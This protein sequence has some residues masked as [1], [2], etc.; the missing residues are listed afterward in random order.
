M[1][2]QEFDSIVQRKRLEAAQ[3]SKEK[4]DS[5]TTIYNL[6]DFDADSA[7]YGEDV[8]LRFGGQEGVYFDA[9]ETA[10]YDEQGQ[11]K[12]YP[13]LDKSGSKKWELHKA[14]YAKRFGIPAEEVTQQMLHDEADKQAL[15][16]Q[17]AIA[18][19][20]GEY[21]PELGVVERIPGQDYNPTGL[22]YAA[23]VEMEPQL[24]FPEA[25][26]ELHGTGKYG[27]P[28]GDYI[29][30]VTGANIT[31]QLNTPEQ[32]AAY[33]FYGNRLAENRKRE[34][35]KLLGVDDRSGFWNNFTRG[36]S[37]NVDSLQA[38]GYGL[39]ALIAD[40]TGDTELAD[41]MLAD[42]Q[43]N[44]AEALE[45][46]KH[47]PD[48]QDVNWT[49]PDD[50]LSALGY[51]VGQAIPS[52]L[53][54]FT[55]GGIG[56]YAAKKAV[57]RKIKDWSKDKTKEQIAKRVVKS[58]RIGQVLGAATVGTGMSTGE[59]YGDL[60]TE[61]YRSTEAQL[62]ALAGGTVAGALDVITPARLLKKFGLGD[63]A[64]QKIKDTLVKE[65]IAK[66]FANVG[67][68]GLKVGVTEGVTE[69]LQFV[70]EEITK[71]LVKTGEL[72]EFQSEQFQ[73][74]VINNIGWG[75][76]GGKSIGGT[77]AI[78]TE[79]SK[80]IGGNKKVTQ[81][82]YKEVLQEAVKEEGNIPDADKQQAEARLNETMTAIDAV[83]IDTNIDPNVPIM[84]KV[85][86]Y[87]QKLAELG[88]QALESEDGRLQ[89]NTAQ[90][91]QALKEAVDEYN[92]VNKAPVNEKVDAA[93]TQAVERIEKINEKLEDPEVSKKH[94]KRLE[95]ERKNQATLVVALDRTDGVEVKPETIQQFKSAT[96]D[97]EY[98]GKE[99]KAT[100]D[101]IIDVAD[102][103]EE[104]T[105]TLQEVET[106]EEAAP[107]EVAEARVTWLQN[108][109]ELIALRKQQEETL[110][111]AKGEQQRADA[112]E[113]IDYINQRLAKGDKDFDVKPVEVA[114]TTTT[115]N[116]YSLDTTDLTNQEIITEAEKVELTEEDAIT[117]DSRKEVV[118]ITQEIDQLLQN[119][120]PLQ[121][122]H[123]DV[124]R[125]T[126]E[127][128]RGFNAYLDDAK[129]N[130]F[131]ATKFDQFKD[132]LHTK[133]EQFTKAIGEATK[134]NKKVYISKD[135][136]SIHTDLPAD[137]IEVSYTGKK[138][139]NVGY[140]NYWWVT[141]KSQKLA[142]LID[143]EAQLANKTEK[144]INQIIKNKDVRQEQAD[145]Q[146][147]IQQANEQ[148]EKLVQKQKADFGRLEDV[149][150]TEPTPSPEK[151]EKRETEKPKPE[152][153]TKPTVTPTEKANTFLGRL[154][155]EYVKLARTDFKV[156][157]LF[158]TKQADRKSFFSENKN[159][160]L[161]KE[162]I[163]AELKALGV[164]DNDFINTVAN[165]FV[166]FKKAFN[167]HVK[168]GLNKHQQDNGVLVLSDSQFVFA[169]KDGNL[170]DEVLFSMMLSVVEWSMINRVASNSTNSSALAQFLFGDSKQTAY[171][172]D[173]QYA[174]FGDMGLPIRNVAKNLSNEIL[175]NLNIKSIKSNSQF[176]EGILEKHYDGKLDPKNTL[177]KDPIIGKRVGTALGLLAIETA[178]HMHLP[179]ADTKSPIIEGGLIDL[180]HGKYDVELFDDAEGRFENI[181]KGE[182]L[183]NTIKVN[184]N[185]ATEKFLEKFKN[186][187][188][189]LKL[190]KGVDTTFKGIHAQPV[191]EVQ[192]TADDSLFPLHTKTKRL[193]KTMQNVAWTG[194]S[195]ELKLFNLVDDEN[196]NQLIELK[197]IEEQHETVR[198][199]VEVAN[200]EKL[201]DVQQVR[202]FMLSGIKSFYY[203]YKVMSQHR[204]RIDSNDINGQRSKIHRALF[205]PEKLTAKVESASDR[206]VFKVAVAQALGF[207]IDKTDLPEVLDYFN[208][209]HGNLAVTNI[210]HTLSK[211][212]VDKKLFNKQLK[213]L[214]ETDLVSPSMHLLEGLV[215]LSQYRE[216]RAFTTRIGIETDGITNG[217]A[218]GL[219]QF[220]G[221]KPEELKARLAK[222]GVF[223]NEGEATQTY[224]KF[225]KSGAT[226]VY[227]S[228][229]ELI[230]KAF[231][232]LDPNINQA[233]GVLHG[234]LIDT[235]TGKIEKFARNL[236]KTPLM[237]SN[238]GAGL[239]KVIDDIV[240]SIVPG[241]YDKMADIQTRYDKAT[242]EQEKQDLETEL[243]AIED[244]V[245]E[246][247]RTKVRLVGWMTSEKTSLYKFKFKYNTTRKLN[248]AFDTIYRK[249]VSDALNELIGPI[250]KARE[251]IVQ[252]VELQYFAF[253]YKFTEATKGVRDITLK[254]AIARDLANKYMP[255]TSGPWS[256]NSAELIQLVKVVASTDARVQI[257]TKPIK[258][259]L[260]KDGKLL[261]YRSPKYVETQ[262]SAVDYRSP[263]VSAAIGMIQNID[264]VLLGEV[265]LHNPNVIPIYDAEISSVTDAFKNTTGYN[266][267]FKRVSLQYSVLEDTLQQTRDVL[268]NLTDAEIKEVMLLVKK[269]GYI[270]EQLIKARRKAKAEPD[271]EK[272]YKILQN[273]YINDLR[274]KHAKLSTSSILNNVQGEIT[275]VNDERKALEKAY[276]KDWVGGVSQM[277]LHESIS[278]LDKQE[279]EQ[280]DLFDEETLQSID[281]KVDAQVEK[282][283][284]TSSLKENLY[285]IFAALGG[286]HSHTYISSTEQ[287]SQTN[288]LQRLLDEVISKAGD[289]LDNITL[290]LN[291]ADIKA[292]GEANIT[293]EHVDVTYN[294]YSPRTYAEQ[295]AQEV[296]AH[297]LIH[298][299]TR[300]ATLANSAF[301]RELRR[302]RNEVKKAIEQEAKANGTKPYEIFLYKKSGQV[303][304][305][306]DEQSEIEAAKAQY[307]YVFG[308]KVPTKAV[309]DEFLA[310]ALTNK[311]LVQKLKQMPASQVDLWS[312]SDRDTVV[313]KLVKFF[314]NVIEKTVEL[315]NKDHRP[316]T[317]EEQIFKLTR[318]IVAVNQNK[319][320]QIS[321]ALKLAEIGRR[322]DQANEAMSHFLKEVLVDKI[323]IGSDKYTAKLK[324]LAKQ[325][326]VDKFR[327]KLLQSTRFVSML[328]GSYGQFIRKHP[329]M[330][331]HLSKAYRSVN[332]GAYKNLLSLKPTTF[333]GVDQDFI[334]LL[335]HSHDQIDSRRRSYKEVVKQNLTKGFLTFDSLE[336][337]DKEAIT[338][339]LLKTDL[340]V[341]VD[342]GD[343]TVDE[344]MVLISD[345]AELTKAINKYAQKV[346][347]AKNAHY[348]VQ[349]DQLAQFMVRGVTNNHNQFLNAHMI[350]NTDPNYTERHAETAERNI[351]DLEVYISLLALS[352]TTT[353]MKNIFVQVARNEYAQNATHNGIHSVINLHN[354]FKHE[355]LSDAFNN[356]PTLMTKG[357]IATITDP[358]IELI[359]DKSDPATIEYYEKNG[360]TYLGTATEL[361]GVT[362][363]HN[364]PGLYV[365]KNN[366]E[367]KRTKGILSATAKKHK[368]TTLRE[369]LYTIHG[370]DH[371]KVKATINQFNKRQGRLMNTLDKKNYT[372]V[373]IVNEKH[374][375]VDYRISMKH[376][377]I[378]QYMDQN[379]AFEDVMSTM[380][381]HVE[382]KI[383]T[384]KI[385]AEAI[386]LLHKYSQD[387]YEDNPSK[388]INILDDKYYDEYVLPFPEH[389]RHLITERA[390]MNPDTKK[391]EFFVDM[392]LLDTVFGY[393]NPSIA[394]LRIFNT[395]LKHRRYAKV[396]EKA[397]QE[398]VRTAVVNIVIRIPIVPTVNAISNFFTSM[399][400]GVP[401]N[402]LVKHWKEGILELQEYRKTAQELMALDIEMK[403]DPAARAD[404]EK[405][406]HRE[407]LVHELNNNAVAPLIDAGLFTSITEDI[408][409]DDFT[410]RNKLSNKLK[411]KGNKVVGGAFEVANHAYLGEQTA[412]F[413]GLM[414]FTQ[415]S[416]FIA[417]YTLYKYQ[418]EQ[419][420]VPHDK[421]WKQ[422]IE[423]FVNYDQPINRYLQVTNDWG[424]I[425]FV[426]YFLNIQRAGLNLIVDKPVNAAMI[427]LGNTALDMDIETIF[428]SHF[429]TGNFLPTLGGFEKIAEEVLVP[430]GVEILTGEGF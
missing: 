57:N 290:T 163:V 151:L 81:D 387:N 345:K 270:A 302:L 173:E 266:N 150:K 134:Q 136:L 3:K 83:G 332:E 93:A 162:V 179:K 211:K 430:P 143:L 417:R 158:K 278:D 329:K 13:G 239:N 373:P 380:Y 110:E 402:Y 320:G 47:I 355:S 259:G 53:A 15:T 86:I 139:A 322:H 344:L 225:L 148:I 231:V 4:H 379:L 56:G 338:K 409:Q 249:P 41:E 381:S 68:E 172:S 274:A 60:G 106:T 36:V 396:A 78:V 38:T 72:P 268:G 21:D 364:S 167:D 353:D 365:I 52:I 280:L 37:G 84:E 104:S 7:A 339:V 184:T 16:A 195:N 140:E 226:D 354:S 415:I 42:Y 425:M 205:A 289:A 219:M 407:K 348:R 328:T 253:Q 284:E 336:S 403:S 210:L 157:D 69:G 6:Q 206:A 213:E 301:K 292:Q 100:T 154:K 200:T 120:T 317:L 95:Q 123:E 227:E 360:Y 287:Q 283:Y 346:G 12:P 82:K 357:Y 19:G 421:A 265:L 197:N 58:Q 251:V 382:D 349:A 193:I 276:G 171:I 202:D 424:L 273:K 241:I 378:Q 326:K 186:N 390:T 298:M 406:R 129:N 429:I 281:D 414:H 64:T 271:I 413:K 418:T 115:D 10:K 261:D 350:Y 102:K 374:Q 277:F 59:I 144:L 214:L 337:V 237:I 272:Q 28:L 67:K 257:K 107:V 135:D 303:V 43:A 368:G 39:A 40:A 33:E 240:D 311:F 343:Y 34:T 14:S 130:R 232:N 234:K 388:F 247:T 24:Y 46:G 98:L 121:R 238:Y 267:M 228:L 333:G 371:K 54:M 248:K 340:S 279:V 412:V 334:N 182:V 305:R 168:V 96:Q 330:Q 264:S 61:G 235:D 51:G 291:K 131:D 325:G 76:I 347:V 385:N 416:D 63:S 90:A 87:E 250:Q 398:M 119:N 5:L 91:Q 166:A 230:A 17:L 293:A 209:V 44:I 400:Y 126:D 66:A 25:D 359:T 149:A 146:S 153:K 405:I 188:K 124:M 394:N 80:Q 422:M 341:L 243:K 308:D 55:G 327:H 194:K 427:F 404:K 262:T 49:D 178:R 187:S 137:A 1:S 201:R 423:T 23:G 362:S 71:E 254:M 125:G 393:Q 370:D 203:R 75:F 316:V 192:E 155:E 260:Y 108:R 65:S 176:L 88:D 94:K 50:A 314:A 85:T 180:I 196:M 185:A 11:L 309:I 208:E 165:E 397:I 152:T 372:M 408:N 215:A 62:G 295:D 175:N 220:L 26:V 410:Y 222:V 296:Y 366:P 156:T 160:T 207:D 282:V 242:T 8:Q 183:L 177:I 299:L 22:K 386:D 79:T 420:N 221:G 246:L 164:D 224:E 401:P 321:R 286:I 229:G 335:Y 189:N 285:S 31:E 9:F 294:Q 361:T 20:Q 318:D 161:T 118:E 27:R 331:K 138:P 358:D 236:A 218:I 244:A 367:T 323:K 32:N 310:Y 109:E 48:F 116:L 77:T 103:V 383:S 217:Y 199:A 198:K 181:D 132:F 35:A 145:V 258:T 319:R 142:K 216:N 313:E 223:V 384:E 105:A 190:I 369:I 411:E 127:H 89:T 29:N 256:A 169:D 113:L 70:V 99:A 363:K 133:A 351:K 128:Y 212:D 101:E 111:V 315:F 45:Q 233:I 92:A 300:Q 419:K 395:S 275:R 307:E 352:K 377:T 252:A 18:E 74:D 112:K 324:K 204:L 30:P 255:R 306:V 288:H 122:T 312:K 392:T 342:T 73:H 2:N 263:G 97:I 399:A 114:D 174:A 304:Y 297:E 117:L 426:K 428:N 170:P 389:A 376:H 375:I 191:E 159:T 147:R 141:P 391:L 245:Y 269:Q 356:S